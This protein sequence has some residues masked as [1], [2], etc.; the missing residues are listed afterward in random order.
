MKGKAKKILENLFSYEIYRVKWKDNYISSK[1]VRHIPTTVLKYLPLF[2][3]EVT[4]RYYQRNEY[5]I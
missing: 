3:I 5:P 1:Y 2:S 4:A